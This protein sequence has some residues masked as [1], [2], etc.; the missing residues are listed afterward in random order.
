VSGYRLALSRGVR[1]DD[2]ALA[3][4]WPQAPQILSLRD[5]AL[6]SFAEKLGA[7]FPAA[8]EKVNELETLRAVDG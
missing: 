7:A 4:T 3:I 6:S 8:S 1:W 5:H 2:A